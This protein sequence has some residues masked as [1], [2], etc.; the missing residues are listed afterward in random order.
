MNGLGRRPVI[1]DTPIVVS[2]TTHG[3]RLA[4]VH[5]TIESIA[6]G[7]VKP[8]RLMLWLGNRERDRPLPRALQRLQRRGLEVQ[9]ADDVGPHTK[10]F[11]YACS[12]PAHRLPLVTADDDMWYPPFWLARLWQAHRGEPAQVHGYR[13]RRVQLVDGRLAPYETWPFMDDDRPGPSVFATG[14]G[15]V[16]YPPALLDRLREQGPAFQACCPKADDIWLHASAL[17]HGFLARQLDREVME[18]RTMPSTQSIGLQNQNVG[19]ALNDVQAL[20]TYTAADLAR[21]HL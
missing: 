15:G 9:Y 2:L 14:V 4:R 3:I 20:A 13:A 6:R 18:F 7:V 10:Y 12:E 19:M 16:V 8:R 1:G 21:M 17:R 11:P 5:R